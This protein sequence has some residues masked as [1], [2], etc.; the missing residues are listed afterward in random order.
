MYHNIKK[1]QDDRLTIIEEHLGRISQLEKE[2]EYLH[3]KLQDYE[4]KIV[5][6]ENNNILR[7]ELQP[8]HR[9]K[10]LEY[11]DRSIISNQR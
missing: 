9:K 3:H 6:L 11:F 5:Y 2:K 1:N 7:K 4:T 10:L 8:L